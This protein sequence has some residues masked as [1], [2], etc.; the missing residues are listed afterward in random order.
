[1]EYPKMWMSISEMVALGFSRAQL[2]FDVHHRRQDFAYKTPRG[3]KWLINPYKYEKFL[4]KERR[5]V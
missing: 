3:G 2:N 5:T 1:M 4:T